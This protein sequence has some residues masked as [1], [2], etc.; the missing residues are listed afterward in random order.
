MRYTAW[1]GNP[2]GDNEDPTRCIAEVFDR[3][4]NDHRLTRQ[5][6]RDRGWKL[7]D[8][9]ERTKAAE[10]LGY[11]VQ[12]V[13]GDDGLSVYYKKKVPDVPCAWQ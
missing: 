10:Q 7:L 12:I 1:S 9:Y 8:L 11:D 5:C 3:M 2:C 13:A 4:S 6:L